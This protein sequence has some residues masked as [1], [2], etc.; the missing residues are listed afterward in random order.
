MARNRVF[1]E[2]LRYCPKSRKKPGFF[3]HDNSTEVARN[4]VFLETLRG[5]PKSRKKPG[6]F[7]RNAIP[8]I[9]NI[10]LTVLDTVLFLLP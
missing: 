2:I 3:D 4:R 9:T 1:L 8:G 10:E 5:R 7:S 6:F